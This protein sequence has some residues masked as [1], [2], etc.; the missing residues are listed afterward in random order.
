MTIQYIKDTDD[1]LE[2]HDEH[3]EVIA[4]HVDTKVLYVRKVGDRSLISI[5]NHAHPLWCLESP[6]E[7]AVALSCEIEYDDDHDLDDGV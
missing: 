6:G 3:G 5:K 1:Y 4:F 7:I 2:L